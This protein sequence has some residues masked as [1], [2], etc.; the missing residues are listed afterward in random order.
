MGRLDRKCVNHRCQYPWLRKIRDRKPKLAL[1][2]HR[3]EPLGIQEFVGYHAKN[4]LHGSRNLVRTRCRFHSTAGFYK[5]GVIELL[6]KTRQRA[7][8]TWL[9]DFQLSGGGTDAFRLINC[10]K[11]WQ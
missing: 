3:I 4:G 10:R 1:S 8:D 7:A 11:D 2:L 5:E 9:A 6:T